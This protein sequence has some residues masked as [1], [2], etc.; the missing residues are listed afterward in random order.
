VSALAREAK[1]LQG[2]S[3]QKK[4]DVREEKKISI[5]EAPAS[6]FSP[7]SEDKHPV[8]EPNPAASQHRVNGTTNGEASNGE[9]KKE[10]IAKE[11]NKETAKIRNEE[12]S[13]QMTAAAPASNL[14]CLEDPNF[15]FDEPPSASP[16]VKPSPSVDTTAHPAS[17]SKPPEP[18]AAQPKK[19]SYRVLEDPEPL[20]L[21][22]PKGP[23]YK[24]LEDPMMTSIYEPAGQEPV[25]GRPESVGD[26]A[27]QQFDKFF[28]G[29]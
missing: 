9:A 22:K 19:P 2:K 16:L 29:N 14:K 4:E 11:N 13:K 15:S 6:P 28:K 25:K 17:D 5:S 23:G 26:G 20:D 24:V 27:R 1:E 21:P 7:K 10:N 3:N 8:T 12:K 18:T